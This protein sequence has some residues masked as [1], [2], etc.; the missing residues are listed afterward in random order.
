VTSCFYFFPDKNGSY[1]NKLNKN[2]QKVKKKITKLNCFHFKGNTMTRS[3]SFGSLCCRPRSTTIP[4]VSPVR[5]EGI[6][7]EDTTFALWVFNWL[8]FIWIFKLFWR[9]SIWFNCKKMLFIKSRTIRFK[10]CLPN[11]VIDFFPN[12]LN[13]RLEGKIIIVSVCCCCK[14]MSNLSN[15]FE[16]SYFLLMCIK[17]KRPLNV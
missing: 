14:E 4:S 7:F 1:T 11:W 17:V 9:S 8:T 12:W 15:F 6:E 5:M 10:I 13:V 16:K 3:D 2:I